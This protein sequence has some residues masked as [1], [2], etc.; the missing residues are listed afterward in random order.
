MTSPEEN[1]KVLITDP[2]EM[3]IYELPDKEFRIV[4]LRNFS[5]QQQG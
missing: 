2:E 4:L 3:E 1:F 5:K